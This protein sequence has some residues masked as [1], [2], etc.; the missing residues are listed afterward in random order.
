MV[1][2]DGP[3]KMNLGV[4]TPWKGLALK[5]SKNK[6]QKY[7]TYKFQVFLKKSKMNNI[8]TKLIKKKGHAIDDNSSDGFGF[9]FMLRTELKFRKIRRGL[10][11]TFLLTSI[12]YVVEKLMSVSKI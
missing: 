3:L 5:M 12:K 11:K 6:Y 2:Q 8:S 10:N 4:L 7:S 9:Y 1:A